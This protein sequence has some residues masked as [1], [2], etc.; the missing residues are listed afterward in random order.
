MTEQAQWSEVSTDEVPAAPRGAATFRVRYTA[1]GARGPVPMTGLVTVP[2]HRRE[3]GAIFSWAHGTTGL[4]TNS[5]P[6]LH[7]S[8]DSIER[9]ITP[10]TQYLQHWVDAGYV[11]TQ[12]DYEGLG[13]EEVGATYMHKASLASSIN[14]LVEES[15]DKFGGSGT[16]VNV[17]F[18]QG[19]YAALAAADNPTEGMAATVAIAP[20]DTELVNKNLRIMGVRPVDVARM[21]K[22]TAVRFFPIVIAGA[23]NAFE[24]VHP[25]DF[26]SERGRELVEKAEQLTLPQLRDEVAN[27]SGGE[28]FISKANTKPMQDL[29]DE[30]RLELMHPQ[31]PVFIVAG[32]QDTTINRESLKTVIKGWTSAGGADVEYREIADAT[33]SDTVPQSYELQREWLSALNG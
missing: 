5:A 4:S 24:G 27:T 15:R 12:P 18:S 31:G 14:R 33:H 25:D 19:G 11:V 30:Q 9:Y 1:Q 10:W 20:G 17:G 13:V 23:L 21:L 16:W 28:L 8:G 26:L 29:L 32:D 22:G 6:S 2:A 7:V 3:D